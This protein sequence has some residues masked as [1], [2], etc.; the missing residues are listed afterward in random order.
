MTVKIK[1]IAV[2]M[3]GTEY[4]VPPLT[5]GALE[6]LMPKISKMQGGSGGN[7]QINAEMVDTILDCSHAALQ[8]NYPDLQRDELR[9]L[10]DVG[11]MMTVFEAVMDVSGLKRKAAEAAGEA[12]AAQTS[13]S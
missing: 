9:E 8:R 3:G 13:G 11:N 1:G 4:I 10:L 7:V 12:A 2:E 6:R 5:L